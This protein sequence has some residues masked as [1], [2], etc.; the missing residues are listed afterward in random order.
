MINSDFGM[1][2]LFG[3]IDH[4]KMKHDNIFLYPDKLGQPQK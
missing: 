2:H 4:L 3:N 1:I